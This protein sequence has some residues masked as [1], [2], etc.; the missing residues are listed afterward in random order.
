MAVDGVGDVRLCAFCGVNELPPKNVLYCSVK[1]RNGASTER[2]KEFAKN[3][4]PKCHPDRDHL[5]LG[6]CGPCYHRRRK[7]LRAG[8]DV[9]A[10]YETIVH[11]PKLF[12]IERN[13]SRKVRRL[14]KQTGRSKEDIRKEVEFILS[15]FKVCEI[16]GTTENL[17]I[18]HDHKL[19][20]VRGVLCFK[21]NFLIGV[22]NENLQVLRAAA[23]YINT[24]RRRANQFKAGIW[25]SSEGANA[26]GIRC[27]WRPSELYKE[28]Y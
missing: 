10:E 23:D 13:I 4:V 11:R 25:A 24:G 26:I 20:F 1:C 17:V 2:L 7:R 14:S 16:C 15:E 9:S 22:A 19:G 8:F 6:L 27:G 3:V 18:D 21:H 28:L 12:D 5:A